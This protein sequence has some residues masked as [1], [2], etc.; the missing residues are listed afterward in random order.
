MSLPPPTFS[1]HP[2]LSPF[3]GYLYRHT[4]LQIR[5]CGTKIGASLLMRFSECAYLNPKLSSTQ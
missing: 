5:E 1:A 3:M 2:P 4:E